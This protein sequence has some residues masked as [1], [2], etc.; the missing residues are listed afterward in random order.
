[1]TP[2]VGQDS[3]RSGEQFELLPEL[4]RVREEAA[5]ATERTAARDQGPGVEPAPELPIAR[6]LVDVPLPH[7]DREFDY[8]VPEVMHGLVAPGSRVKLRFAGQDV[9][10]YVL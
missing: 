7:L 3:D 6:V 8:L 9:E 1:M 5:R 10:G 2:H 4:A